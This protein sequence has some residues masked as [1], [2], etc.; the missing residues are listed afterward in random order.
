MLTIRVPIRLVSE[1]NARGHWAK[2][3]G[4]AKDV[5]QA[6]TAAFMDAGHDVEVTQMSPK[7]IV[8]LKFPPVL[9][10]VVFMTRV[11]PRALDSDNAV[12]SCKSVRDQVAELLGV[13]DRDQRITWRVEQRKGAVGEYAVEISIHPRGAQ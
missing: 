8:R 2:K 10:V 6:V 12:R 1:A 4:R 5:R 13:D 9:P 11:A 3:A 7:L